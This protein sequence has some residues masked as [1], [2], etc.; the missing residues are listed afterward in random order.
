MPLA[1]LLL[2]A[3]DPADPPYPHN[4]CDGLSSSACNEKWSVSYWD[5]VVGTM[6]ADG[7]K[8]IAGRLLADPPG[9]KV[10]SPIVERE[11]IACPQYFREPGVGAESEM[12]DTGF[13]TQ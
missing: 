11:T 12:Q 9:G 2:L 3:A 6:P 5:E 1:L 7:F 8:K 13:C 10:Y 4:Y